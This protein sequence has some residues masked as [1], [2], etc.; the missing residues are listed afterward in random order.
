M[1]YLVCCVK[2]ESWNLRL[3]IIYLSAIEVLAII[4]SELEPLTVVVSVENDASLSLVG[5]EFSTWG[6]ILVRKS[7]LEIPLVYLLVSTVIQPKK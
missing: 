1:Y 4:I 2:I 7:N 3:I 6:D 5:G